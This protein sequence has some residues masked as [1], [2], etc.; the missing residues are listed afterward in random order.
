[1][2]PAEAAF[3]GM[4]DAAQRMSFARVERT[5]DRLE[6]PA[7]EKHAHTCRDRSAER[8]VPGRRSIR[9]GNSQLSKLVTTHF[10][11]VMT[12]HTAPGFVDSRLPN[13]HASNHGR[14]N[15]VAAQKVP[16]LWSQPGAALIGCLTVSPNDVPNC[17]DL[18]VVAPNLGL[19]D[20]EP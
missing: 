5:V 7:R 10:L 8:R 18:N 1:M 2:R 20:R 13:K 17:Q 12:L 6:S 3:I 9:G 15:T 19:Q 16:R 11:P 14:M 4:V